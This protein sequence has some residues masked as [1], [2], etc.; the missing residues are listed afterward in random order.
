MAGIEFKA[1]IDAKSIKN[2]MLQGPLK[3]L[4][5]IM[6]T[7]KEEIDT[8]T[9]AGRDYKGN[10]FPAYDSSYAAS[11]ASGEARKTSRKGTKARSTNST[12][13]RSGKPKKTSVNK[14]KQTLGSNKT[15]DLTLWGNMLNSMKSQAKI[16]G[17]AVEG[18]IYFSSKKQADKAR[19]HMTGT[20]F[21]KTRPGK[22]REFFRLSEEQVTQIRERLAS[23]FQKNK[24][25]R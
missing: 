19:G 7:V 3:E 5:D 22:K 18:R 14:S 20:Y 13:P 8:R 4:E 2:A 10:T 25:I 17:N 11:K 21:G 6:L 12:L 24:I 1:N 15:V 23:L 9:R 16:I